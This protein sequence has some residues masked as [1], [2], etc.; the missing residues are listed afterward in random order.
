MEEEN[1]D[2][3]IKHDSSDDDDDMQVSVQSASASAPRKKG[4]TRALRKREKE[5]IVAHLESIGEDELAESIEKKVDKR[6]HMHVY[7]DRLTLFRELTSTHVARLKA[8]CNRL[9]CLLLCTKNATKGK[10]SMLDFR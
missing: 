2:D 9:R 4:T 5:G 8:I 7:E 1:P 3:D 10:T 6:L